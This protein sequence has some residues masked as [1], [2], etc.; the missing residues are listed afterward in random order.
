MAIVFEEITGEIAPASR[1]VEP[2]EQS[3][4]SAAAAAAPDADALRHLQV[5]QQRLIARLS[6]D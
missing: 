3:T 6:A 2:A 5:Q 1:G 4:G